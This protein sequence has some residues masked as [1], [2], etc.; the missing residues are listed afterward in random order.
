M[1]LMFALKDIREHAN[2]KGIEYQYDKYLPKSASHLSR[3][4]NY[5]CDDLRVAG[6][7]VSTDIQKNS[8]RYIG[9]KKA[10]K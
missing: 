4:L 9:F 1:L 8:R 7:I 5:I 2:S 6:L 3:Q 10:Q